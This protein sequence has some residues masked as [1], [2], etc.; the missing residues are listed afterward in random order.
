MIVNG[1]YKG[2]IGVLLKIHEEQYNCDITIKDSK[3]D[4]LGVEYEDIC[5]YDGW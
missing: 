1:K 3:I 2:S 5:K 4:L